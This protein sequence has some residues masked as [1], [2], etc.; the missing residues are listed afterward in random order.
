V[1]AANPF[2]IPFH[3]RH[4]FRFPI[5]AILKR[6]KIVHTGGYPHLG[7]R[8]ALYFCLRN[9][10]GADTGGIDVVSHRKLGYRASSSRGVR[11]FTRKTETVRGRKF[12][13]SPR[14]QLNQ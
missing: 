6:C 4:Q 8:Y 10:A 2:A 3:E 11:R 12:K 14:N 1:L 7:G 9:P 13:S 5:R